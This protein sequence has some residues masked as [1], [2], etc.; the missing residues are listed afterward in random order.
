MLLDRLSIS[1]PLDKPTILHLPVAYHTAIAR[2]ILRIL[3]C[4]LVYYEKNATVTNH[5]CR[6]VV[7][8]SLRRIIFNL[9]HA[10]PIT[11]YKGE[12]KTLYRIK[13]RFSGPVYVLTFQ[14][15]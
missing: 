12:Y 13:L 4:R 14:I 6:I 10:T 15:G 8:T 1:N 2:N 3:E 11:G 5:I 9:M 7:P